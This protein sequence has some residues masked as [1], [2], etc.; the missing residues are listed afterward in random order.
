[1]EGAFF[2][3]LQFDYVD[4][5][6]TLR[7]LF[8]IKAD[9]V[10]FGKALKAAALDGRMVYKNISI[11]FCSNKAKT[12]AVVEPLHCSLCHFVYLLISNIKISEEPKKKGPQS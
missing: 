12:F 1:M 2:N 6:G 7:A 11:V 10:T 4:R 8:G 3:S 9:V 5:F